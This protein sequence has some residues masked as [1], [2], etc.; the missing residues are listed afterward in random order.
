VRRLRDVAR[1][2]SAAVCLFL[3]ALV[4]A[5]CSESDPPA[6]EL[7]SCGCHYALPAANPRARG[8]ETN[9][10]VCGPAGYLGGTASADAAAIAERGCA[11]WPGASNCVCLCEPLGEVCDEGVM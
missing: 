2:A 5:A 3:A 7:W 1:P 11:A 6:A 9:D 8:V 10:W 4:G